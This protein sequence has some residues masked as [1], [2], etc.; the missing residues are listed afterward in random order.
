MI[1]PKF[2]LFVGPMFGGKTTRLL[3]ALDRY[4]YQKKNI[5]LFKPKMDERYNK[6]N[7]TTHN[8]IKSPRAVLVETG[9]ELYS[10]FISID[11][12]ESVDIVAVDEAFMIP[13]CAD[14]LIKIYKARAKTIVVSSI[15][16][17]SVGGVMAEVPKMMPWATEMT[18]CPAVC[19]ECGADAHFTYKKSNQEN[20]GIE[21]GGSEL[22]ESL[23]YY[24]F[25]AKKGFHDNI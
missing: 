14:A 20:I 3:A 21:V 16:L 19:F 4:R 2:L 13:G 11:K 8:G 25:K 9:H 23:C 24:H 15:Q 17:N 5:L 6:E 12:E 7:V 1:L 22:Y 10:T 18:V